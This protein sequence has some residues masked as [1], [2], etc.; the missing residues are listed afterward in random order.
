MQGTGVSNSRDLLH[1]VE[2]AGEVRDSDGI[3]HRV[4][5]TPNMDY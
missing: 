1:G 5:K 4:R 3:L 2:R